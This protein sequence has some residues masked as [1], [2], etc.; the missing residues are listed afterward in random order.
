MIIRVRRKAPPHWSCRRQRGMT[1]GE[2]GRRSHWSHDEI[3]QRGESGHYRVSAN[4]RNFFGSGVWST[5][6]GTSGYEVF[7][8]DLRYFPS[9]VC[10]NGIVLADFKKSSST[11]CSNKQNTTFIIQYTT[12]IY[13]K[14]CNAMP[15]SGG[16][17]QLGVADVRLGNA[18]LDLCGVWGHLGAGRRSGAQWAAA[19]PQSQIMVTSRIDVSNV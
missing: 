12:E 17:D 3:W 13:T 11:Y 18:D 1:D 16:G 4:N 8:T 15:G 7:P 14:R 2:S 9:C 10:K 6:R 5:Y 19:R